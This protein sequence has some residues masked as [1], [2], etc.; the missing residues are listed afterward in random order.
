MIIYIADRT[1]PIEEIAQHCHACG[2]RYA[3]IVAGTDN[4]PQPFCPG[5][6]SRIVQVMHVINTEKK[7]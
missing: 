6:G 1:I 5:C 4:T 3:V 2:L 7:Q